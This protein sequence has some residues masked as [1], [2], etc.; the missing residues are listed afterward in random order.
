MNLKYYCTFPLP[1]SEEKYEVHCEVP[2]FN[3]VV[4]KVLSVLVKVVVVEAFV[5]VLV[6]GEVDLIHINLPSLR[7][8]QSKELR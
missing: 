7:I 5:V 3:D 4:A 1:F 6:E 2:Y 8:M